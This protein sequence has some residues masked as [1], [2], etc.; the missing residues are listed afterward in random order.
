[1]RITFSSQ[2]SFKNGS[3]ILKWNI[4]SNE[5]LIFNLFYKHE[6]D[7]NW[8]DVVLQ[9]VHKDDNSSEY[10]LEYSFPNARP[11]KYTCQIQSM[12]DFGISEKSVE[13]FAY[14]EEEVNSIIFLWC[15]SEASS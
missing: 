14:K 11:G 5:N 8:R 13:I 12:C 3:L 7:E 1:M 2:V 4:V 15:N 10:R 6:N 9:N